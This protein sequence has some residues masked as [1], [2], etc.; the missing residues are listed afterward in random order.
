MLARQIA[1][2]CSAQFTQNRQDVNL[3]SPNFNRRGFVRPQIIGGELR[4]QCARL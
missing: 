3:I 1:R 2:L 4:S